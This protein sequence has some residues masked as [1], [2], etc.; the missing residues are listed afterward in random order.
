MQDFGTYLYP[1]IV[2]NNRTYRGQLDKEAVANAL[3]AGFETAPKECKGF[4]YELTKDGAAT[5]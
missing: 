3:C 1:S 2:I 4:D 5:V